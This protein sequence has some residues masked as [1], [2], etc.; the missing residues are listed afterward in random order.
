MR[1]YVQW[2]RNLNEDCSF[3]R[4]G[5]ASNHEHPSARVG[6]FLLRLP[7]QPQT[8]HLQ[9]LLVSVWGLKNYKTPAQNHQRLQQS[10]NNYQLRHA[11]HVQARANVHVIPNSDHVKQEING[12]DGAPADQQPTP[13]PSAGAA[14]LPVGRDVL[15]GRVVET[16]ACEQ[17][18]EWPHEATE[19]GR[20]DT[21]GDQ[22]VP[23][24]VNCNL[25]R[26]AK[27]ESMHGEPTG[28]RQIIRWIDV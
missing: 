22:F 13:G 19:P 18:N 25:Y 23:G 7:A 21:V 6:H 20:G 5:K 2:R 1:I 15:A 14:G 10:H 11:Q 4:T 3:L 28:H 16:D 27:G 8:P 17:E 26:E 12:H 9:H 24:Y